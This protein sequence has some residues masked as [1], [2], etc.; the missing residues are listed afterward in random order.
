MAKILK[1]KHKNMNANEYYFTISTLKL[2]EMVLRVLG[3][4]NEKINLKKKHIK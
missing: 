2:I 4:I 1:N 3:Y